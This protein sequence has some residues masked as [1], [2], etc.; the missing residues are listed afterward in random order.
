M[1]EATNLPLF[2]R[3]PK[4]LLPA[5]HSQ[6]SL[7]KQPDY[8]FAAQTNA[9]PLVAEE[10]PVAA[11]HYPV[12]F[13]DEAVAHPVALLGVRAQQN[14][15]VDDQG[16]WQAGAYVPAYVR[17]YP[18]IFLENDA[19]TELTLCVDEAAAQF[20]EGRAN[21][22]FDLHGEPTTLARSALAFCR[23]Y[24]A[25]HLAA[26]EFSKAVSAAGLFT[27]HR[28]DLTLRDGQRM[29]LAGFKVIDE[30]RFARLPDATLLEWRRKGWLPMVYGHFFSIGAWSAL[31]DRLIEG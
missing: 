4:V 21:P 26:V 14:L 11:R 2:Y 5:A 13:S 27:D 8:G 3:S 28:A 15:F 17:R 10:I 12:V 6:R 30:N 7:A 9:V 25:Q 23:D 20:V 31:V 22:L 18:F 1:T 29:S 19:G 24:Q 16:R